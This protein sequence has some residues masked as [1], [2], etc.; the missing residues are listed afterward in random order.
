MK[1]M[2]NKINSYSTY[3]VDSN[4]NKIYGVHEGIEGNVSGIYGNVSRIEGNVS[5]IR[6]DV[7]GI[8]GNVSGISG[9]LDDCE[10]T[11]FD[12]KNGIDINYLCSK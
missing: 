4:K 5:G 6:G 8:Y 7:S 9:N 3:Y 1:K 10:I 12:R 11:E 2:L